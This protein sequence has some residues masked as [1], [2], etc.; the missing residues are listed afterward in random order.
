V[1]HTSSSMSE[2]RSAYEDVTALRRENGQREQP[3]TVIHASTSTAALI[4]ELAALDPLAYAQRR[5]DAAKRLG[6]RASDIDAAVKQARTQASAAAMETLTTAA[7]AIWPEPVA[8]DVLLREVRAFIARFVIVDEHAVTALTL[9]IAFT[10]AFAEAETSPRLAIVSPAMRCGKTRLLDVLGMLC[11]RAVSASN[12]SPSA[13]FRAIDAEQPTLLID[14]ADTFARDNDE[15]RGLLNSGHTR[16]SAYVIRS[17]PTPDGGWQAKR[18][19]TWAPIA[20]AAIGK[21]PPTWMDRSIVIAMRRKLPSQSVERLTRRNVAAREQAAM[22]AS[23][24]ARFAA[25]NLDALR[26]AEPAIP[27]ALNDR[28]ADNWDLL[29]AIANVAGLGAEARAAAL[30]LSGDRETD[31]DDSLSIRLLYDIK[32]ILDDGPR[33]RI[34]S[35]ELCDALTKLETSPWASITRGKPLT[36]ARLARMLKSYEILPSRDRG[37]S[38]YRVS[39]FD[40]AFSRYLPRP[41]LQSANVRETLRRVGESALLKVRQEGTTESSENPRESNTSRTF[42]LSQRDMG[43]E[44]VFPGV[45]RHFGATPDRREF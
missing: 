38:T 28:A 27:A 2:W 10:H 30:A 21:L 8:A 35:S 41:L 26:N 7:P 42:A 14:E 19:S 23:K 12:L 32:S 3:E 24:L 17:V 25:D 11:P 6:V 45:D 29:L 13:I 5:K 31:A 18:F 22:L 43:A 15:L 9:W 1:E 40:D 37:G 44:H 39:D 16:T 20:V 33:E 4:A 36:P 34:G